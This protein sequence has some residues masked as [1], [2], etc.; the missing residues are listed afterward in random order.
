MQSLSNT[1]RSFRP[2]AH[3]HGVKH[4][5]PRRFPFGFVLLAAVLFVGAAPIKHTGTR[6]A[7]QDAAYGMHSGTAFGPAGL[8]LH[9]SPPSESL[10]SPIGSAPAPNAKDRASGFS[11]IIHAADRS[12]RSASARI[13]R[14][15][16][17]TLVALRRSALLFPFHFFW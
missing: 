6:S 12:V 9:H 8:L 10:T 3:A 1:S 15:A 5:N 13:E 11:A 2:S 7:W 4:R 16:G 14:T 17:S